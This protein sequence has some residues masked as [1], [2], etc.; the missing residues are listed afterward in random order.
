MVRIKISKFNIIKISTSV[1][2]S[3][4]INWPQSIKFSNYHS[5]LYL[6]VKE[7]SDHLCWW[8]ISR[9]TEQSSI[10]LRLLADISQCP[11]CSTGGLRENKYLFNKKHFSP[12]SNRIFRSLSTNFCVSGQFRASAGN[13]ECPLPSSTSSFKLVLFLWQQHRSSYFER[14]FCFADPVMCD[15]QSGSWGGNTEHSRGKME[16]RS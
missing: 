1:R 16:V 10:W 8:F 6:R 5:P 2:D 15:V 13:L 12:D 9:C 4:D 11:D 7:W 14:R 3:Q